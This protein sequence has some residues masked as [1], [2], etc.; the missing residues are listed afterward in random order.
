MSDAFPEL[1]TCGTF[2]SSSDLDVALYAKEPIPL[3]TMALLENAL[4]ES[5]LPFTVDCVAVH[6]ISDQFRRIIEAQRERLI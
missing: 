2:K 3:Q 5:V 4:Q 1:F 6:G